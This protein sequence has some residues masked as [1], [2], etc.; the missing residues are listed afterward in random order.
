M[1]AV[2][3]PPRQGEVMAPQTS[4]VTA[5][6]PHE[7]LSRAVLSGATIDVVERLAALVERWD[8]R[9]CRAAFEDALAS[10]REEGIPLIVKSQKVD[11]TTAKGRTSYE[12]ENFA[13]V[14]K[15]ADSV[16]PKHGIAYRFRTKQEGNR[17]VV[18][19][20]ISHRE[21]YFEE[22]SLGA[23]QDESGNKNSIQA[24]GSTV[25]YLERYT[26]KAALG[27]AVGKDDDALSVGNGSKSITPEQLLDLENRM[28]AAGVNVT[29]F[30]QLLKIS[31][32]D[33]LAADR[34]DSAKQ[35]LILRKKLEDER[36][37]KPAE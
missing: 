23:A 6:T 25:T 16:F 4:P 11:F 18:T 15:V 34:Y 30:C 24:V 17:V 7:L 3:L 28:E 33:S 32:L 12:Y 20:V 19:C 8:D 29:Q 22:N 9:R 35:L 13:D 37:S 26:L 5:P 21:G 10:A 2:N 31:T 1:P 27:L 14:A 36:A